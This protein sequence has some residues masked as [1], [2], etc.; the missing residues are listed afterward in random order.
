MTLKETKH[1]ASALF[2]KNRKPTNRFINQFR[3]LLDW[4]GET[5]KILVCT[6]CKHGINYC[7][8]GI[9]NEAFCAQNAPQSGSLHGNP[10]D[11]WICPTC[12]VANPRSNKLG[13]TLAFDYLTPKLLIQALMGQQQIAA[14]IH[15]N[16]DLYFQDE[17]DDSQYHTFSNSELAQQLKTANVKTHHTHE[18]Y[19]STNSKY[20]EPDTIRLTAH[21]SCDGVAVKDK[22]SVV[23]FCL[24]IEE[25]GVFSRTIRLMVS[26]EFKKREVFNLQNLGEEDHEKVF[27]T[28][29]MFRVILDDFARISSDGILV[30]DAFVGKIVKIHISIVSMCGDFIAVSRMANNNG[31]TSLAPCP[32]CV[33]MKD[34]IDKNLGDIDLDL[35]SELEERS[36]VILDDITEFKKFV[37]KRGTLKSNGG[38]VVTRGFFNL[39]RKDEKFYEA[40]AK[41]LNSV[42]DAEK[43]LGFSNISSLFCHDY[44]FGLQ[45]GYSLMFD[46][47]HYVENICKKLR[48]RLCHIYG[49]FVHLN[50][51]N[52]PNEFGEIPT[53]F[54]KS[55]DKS[56]LDHT[57]HCK[58]EQE[59]SLVVLL[60][61]MINNDTRAGDQAEI[62]L[63][64]DFKR[65]FDLNFLI[66]HVISSYHV[67]K[68]DL[69]YFD[70]LIKEFITKYEGDLCNRSQEYWQELQDNINSKY[71]LRGSKQIELE[72][73]TSI[74]L[75]TLCHVTELIKFKGPMLTS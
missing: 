41:L 8:S 10:T 42:P 71:G 14:E 62:Q 75:H 54:N 61:I 25:L 34:T 59:M 58:A 36:T 24:R 67:L 73:M 63:P 47:M 51:I 11:Y 12:E 65:I 5:S 30:F 4:T 49:G 46:S 35:N 56:R 26:P 60:N 45:G 48:K 52:Y 16:Y 13:D 70:T 19:K 37:N 44:A 64:G 74:Y 22:L 21:I 57:T 28:D 50:I 43:I 31:P 53:S 18:G 38:S 39:Q 69:S 15:K 6:K 7:A 40:A 32:H 17:A 29:L 9:D 20:F 3:D 55:D 23:P 66:I 33:I 27:L 68:S 1:I 2:L 72:R